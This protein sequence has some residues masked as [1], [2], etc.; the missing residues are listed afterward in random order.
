MRSNIFNKYAT[1]EKV[2]QED[3]KKLWEL[4]QN[5]RNALIDHVANIYKAE[6]E[7]IEEA[8]IEKAVYEIGG[9]SAKVLKVLSCLR[10]LYSEWNLFLDKPDDFLRD[11]GDLSLV[12]KEHAEEA[13][14]FFLEFLKKVE[15]DNPR[16][17]EKYYANALLP[18]FTGINTKIDFRAMIREP[19]GIKYPYNI[20]KYSPECS[21]LVPI[22][23][24]GIKRDSGVPMTFRFQCDETSLQLFIDTLL[25]AQKDLK[26]AKT[27]FEKKEE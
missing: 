22:I 13:K 15:S 10:F 26:A 12:P 18:S 17:L 11:L 20:S 23:M 7:T 27:F 16:R 2:F 14:V 4:P 24:I 1:L 21:G 25:A 5:A 8:R 9:D 19:Y 3:L 6:T